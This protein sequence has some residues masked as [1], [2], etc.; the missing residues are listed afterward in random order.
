[1]RTVD[2]ETAVL[3]WVPVFLFS[4]GTGNDDVTSVL[5]QKRKGWVESRALVLK[6]TESKVMSETNLRVGLD[7]EP[8]TAKVA[9]APERKYRRRVVHADL[10][11]L[12]VV[13]NTHAYVGI[14]SSTVRKQTVSHEISGFVVAMCVPPDVER[15][16]KSS[17]ENTLIDFP[18][19]VSQ[20]VFAY[21]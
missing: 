18:G 21:T 5:R 20:S 11:L 1:M 3:G 12:G 15:K 4:T 16:L 13:A 17:D 19:S 7:L 2:G 9:L 8:T 14:A 10:L 6:L